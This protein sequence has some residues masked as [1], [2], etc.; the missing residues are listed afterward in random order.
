MEINLPEG[1]T[2]F[3]FPESVRKRLRTS[4]LCEAL[5]KAIRRRTRVA[6]IFPD[7]ASCLRMVPAFLMEISD[8]RGPPKSAS[9]SKPAPPTQNQIRLH[10]QTTLLPFY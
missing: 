5:N 8:D 9:I 3:A 7:G 2:I 4:N 1:L 10:F 6:A